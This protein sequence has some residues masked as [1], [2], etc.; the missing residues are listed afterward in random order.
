MSDIKVG[1]LVMVVRPTTCCHSG[2]RIGFIT[3]VV[4]PIDRRPTAKCMGC[5]YVTEND[6]SM[7]RLEVGPYIKRSRLI[8][9]DPPSE[10]DS[11]PTRADLGQPI[12]A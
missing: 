7:V 2:E 12:T 11:L 10:G 4:A 1:D 9:I 3:R 6:D 5:G 8:K